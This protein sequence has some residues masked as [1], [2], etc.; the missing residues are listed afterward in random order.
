MK[1]YRLHFYDVAGSSHGFAFF[2]SKAVADRRCRAWNREEEGREA[3]VSCVEFVCSKGGVL[4]L[5]GQIAS[6]ADNG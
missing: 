1:I 5:L 6:H 3:S 4:S 2:S